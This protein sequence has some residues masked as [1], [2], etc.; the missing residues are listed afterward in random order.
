LSWAGSPQQFDVPS[1]SGELRGVMTKGQ[2]LKA[3]P[4]IAKLLGV[5]SLQALP[6]RITL[7]FND[8][9]S[10]G[11]S[12]DTI[13]GQAKIERGAATLEGFRMDGPA[14]EVFMTGSVDLARET[15][16]LRVKVRPQVSG[17][18][19]LAAA[20]VNPVAGLA[21][22]VATLL[23]K[24]PFDEMLAYNYHVTGTWAD[25]V[26]TKVDAPRAAVQPSP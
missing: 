26:V 12:F 23:F 14:A 10:E 13:V 7:D 4:G 5:L 18:V 11:F 6:R 21:T 25:S 9:F 15:Q 16:N 1:L 19:A 17:G 24:R 3:D 20:V 22:L 8:V 2:F